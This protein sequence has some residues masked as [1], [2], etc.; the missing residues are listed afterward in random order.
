MPKYPKLFWMAAFYFMPVAVKA[1]ANA[2]E[3]N[4]LLDAE[5]MQFPTYLQK[6]NI[7]P[8]LKDSLAYFARF[9]TDT[10][11]TY[12]N[13][14]TGKT[15]AEKRMALTAARYCLQLVRASL[16]QERI[17]QYDIP[18]ILHTYP[19]LAKAIFNHRDIRGYTANF[20]ARRTQLMADIFR[21]YDEGKALQQLA[22]VRRVGVSTGNIFPFL[23]RTPDFRYM[24]TVL[25]YIAENEPMLMVDY[26]NRNSNPIT[27]KIAGMNHPVLNQLVLL[28]GDRNA[29]EMAPLAAEM[30][31]GDLTREQI[32]N[33]RTNDVPGY[34]QLLVNTVQENRTKRLNGGPAGM[35]PSLRDA[36]H[37]KATAFFINPINKLHEAKDA[38]RFKSLQRLRTI[39]LYY[40][41][42]SDE[43]ELYTSSFLG[44]YKRMMEALPEGHSDSLL[45][46]V[47]FDQFRKFI[48]G[49][50]HYN[51]LSDY[52]NNMPAASRQSLLKN[53]I[54]NVDSSYETGIEDAMDVADAFVGLAPDPVYGELVADLLQENIR[55][56]QTSGSYYGT[57]LYTIL[58]EV[59][60]MARYPE[61]ANAIFRK[62]GNYE[63][64]SVDSLREGDTSVNQLVVFY[65]DEDGKAS[66]RSFMSL[67]KDKK[68]W[69]VVQQDQWT[70]IRS[71]AMQQPIRIFANQ[72]KSSEDGSDERAQVALLSYLQ[73]QKIRPGIIIH[74]GHSYH[75][76]TTLEYLQPYMKLAILGSCGGYKNILT[77]AAKSPAAQIIATKQVGSMLINDPMIQEVNNLLGSHEDIHW[78]EFWAKMET[79]FSKSSFTHDLFAEY[80]PPYRN[81][82]LFVIRLYNQDSGGF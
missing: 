14:A 31:D 42:V 41:L 56:C 72:P 74:R 67:F 60:Q 57:R 63:T 20:G 9:G 3:A 81:L 46:T 29:M 17:V 2:S 37:Q 47:Q 78:P 48:R 59:Y 30:A 69:E 70:E 10:L 6:L 71:L 75:L 24:D 82:S 8:G 38:V 66:F 65:G 18:S 58:R 1:Q 22:D 32:L 55:R 53:F 16:E 4:L 28:K 68:L 35:Q 23:E 7:E 5:Q 26:L 73:E 54:S 50:S 76:P 62:L 27:E 25:I 49:C 64:L 44:V 77:V 80:I 12:F 33:L 19:R 39:D 11:Q 79:Q 21:Q 13:A 61:Q 51:V 15:D 36:L 43:D 45:Y 34:Y 52:L 40:L